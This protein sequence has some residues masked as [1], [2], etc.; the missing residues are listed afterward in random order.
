MKKKIIISIWSD[1]SNYINLLFFINHFIKKK[2]QIVLI[3]QNIDR[4]KDFYYFVKKS[5]YLKIIEIKNKGKIGYF[6]FFISKLNSLKKYKPQTLISINFI[7]LFFSNFLNYK[8]LNWIYYNFDFNFS[9]NFNINNFLEKKIIQNVNS[10]FLPSKS[11]VKLYK[12]KFFRKKNIFS[13]YNCFSKNFKIQNY[14]IK[15]INKKLRKKNYLVRLGSFYKY[16]YL[17][18]L[19]FS[20]KYW[21]KNIYL[22]MAGKSY[23]RY[24]QKLI[25]FKEKNNLHKVILIENISYKKWFILLKNALAGFALYQPINVSHK[26]MG[27]TSQKLNNYIFAGIPSFV[28]NNAD[29]IKF[30]NKFG[31]SIAVDN[32]IKDINEKVNLLLNDKIFYNTKIKNNKKAFQNEFN[33]EKQIYQVEKYII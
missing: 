27:G 9:K 18:E 17:E 22:V 3:C 10:V 23:D 14:K 21:S 16:H 11:R 32:S 19:A 30:N 29:F 15:N 28:S 8:K 1:P 12:K 5:K 13:I 6:Y 4:K 2:I 31:T 33:F 7:S 20:T 24:F 25:Q 26:L